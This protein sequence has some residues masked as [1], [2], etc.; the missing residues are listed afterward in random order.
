LSRGGAQAKAR[1]PGGRSL[2]VAQRR[3]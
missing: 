3:R 2:L 1:H